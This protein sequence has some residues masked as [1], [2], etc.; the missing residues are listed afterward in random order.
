[1]AQRRTG[2]RGIRIHRNYEVAEVANILSVSRQTVLRWIRQ[3]QLPAI[4]NRKPYLILGSDLVDFV[5]ARS[6]PMH[7]CGPHECYCVKCRKPQ[8]P[9]GDMA[10]IVPLSPSSG[11]L[12]ALCP[13]CGTLMHR[14]VSTAKLAALRVILDVSIVEADEP[15]VDTSSPSLNDHLSQ[16]SETHA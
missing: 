14:G 7:R 5:K 11:N 10:E 4:T 9:A 13:V 8:R 16:E 15:I 2:L 3:K 12:R 1:M 6:R